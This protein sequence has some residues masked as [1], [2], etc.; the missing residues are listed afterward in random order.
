M[1]DEADLCG[2]YLMFGSISSPILGF[3]ILCIV[4]VGVG[5]AYLT[6]FSIV[7]ALDNLDRKRRALYWGLASVGTVGGLFF[8]GWAWGGNPFVVWGAC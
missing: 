5:F 7:R 1:S 3:Q 6:M 2:Q 8:Y 4:L